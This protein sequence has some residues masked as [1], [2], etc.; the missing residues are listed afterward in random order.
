[1][2]LLMNDVVSTSEDMVSKVV[3]RRRLSI[4][5]DNV[6]TDTSSQSPDGADNIIHHTHI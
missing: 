5:S 1:M 4:D 3:C 2:T 6:D